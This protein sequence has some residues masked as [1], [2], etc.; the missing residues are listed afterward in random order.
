MFG[1]PGAGMN[2][3]LFADP[4]RM[5][6]DGMLGEMK[7]FGDLAVRESLA[8]EI[9]HLPLSDAVPRNLV[10]W[11]RSERCMDKEARMP[12][13][14]YTTEEIVRRGEE[15]YERSV[16]GKVEPEND[17]RFLAVDVESGDYAVADEALRATARLRER[18]PEAVPN[19]VRV[20][21][22][23]AFRL[24]GPRRPA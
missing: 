8:G 12:H 9:C 6:D 4:T 10:C 17:G 24:G 16:R 21:R 19:L 22:P 7:L 14:E 3:E 20:G 11:D 18:R 2:P 5:G 1:D 23:A 15:I 13:P